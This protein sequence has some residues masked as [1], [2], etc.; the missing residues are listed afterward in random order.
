MKEK[1]TPLMKQYYSI[2]AKYPG[3]ILLFRMGDFFETFDEDAGITAKV[4]GIALTKRNNGAAGESPLAG[5]PHH[6]LDTY[7]PKLIKAGYRV[8]VCEQLEDPKFAKGIVKRGVIEVVTPG[9]AIYDKL[10]DS[11]QNNYLA[12]LLLIKDKYTFNS[13]I[14]SFCDISTGEFSVCNINVDQIIEVLESFQPSELL[15][16]KTQKDEVNLLINQLSYKPSLTKLED[17]IFEPNFGKDKLINHFG[18]LNLKA[19]GIEENKEM[20]SACGAII[21][22]LAE[23]QHNQLQHLQ[24][25]SVFHPGD[26]MIL[27]GPTKRNLEITN[28]ISGESRGATLFSVIDKT[29]TAGGGRLLRKWIN[30]PLKNLE[31]IKMRLNIVEQF[32]N[33]K[34]LLENISNLLSKIGDLERLI[35]KIAFHRCNP[36]DII[37]LKNSLKIIPEIK[38]LLLDFSEFSYITENLSSFDELVHS[39]EHAILEDPTSNLGTGNVFKKGF[40]TELDSYVEAKFSAKKWLDSYQEKL[41]NETGIPTLKIGFN[42][43]FGYYIEITKIHNRKVPQYLERKQTLTNAERYTSPELKE[44]EN[45]IYTAEEKIAELEQELFAKIKE[46]IIQFTQDIQKNAYYL[47]QL[48]CLHSFALTALENNYTK[49]EIGDFDDIIITDGRH[50]VVEKLLPQGVSYT[51]NSTYLSNQKEQIHIITGPNM[52]GKSCYLRQVAL[53]TLLAHIGSYVP[54]KNAKISIVDRI[55]T[56]VGA[57]DNIAGGESTFLIEMQEAG[58]ILNNA[59]RKSLILLDELGRGT[60]T[61]DGL[62]IA[63][64]VTEYIHNNIGAKTLFATHFHELNHLADLYPRIVNYHIEVIDAGSTILFTH[65]VLKGGTDHSFGIYVAKIAGIPQSVIDRAKSIMKSFEDEQK[66]EEAKSKNLDKKV[67][68]IKPEDKSAQLAIFEFRDDKLRERILNLKLD[69]ITPIQ[70]MQ[71][72]AELQNEAKFNK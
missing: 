25:I 28:T 10:L 60:A 67:K 1:L 70:A 47:A 22:Y 41:R 26:F 58:N 65:N 38:N 19:F 45:K 52:S 61:S 44:F 21:Y 53:I 32:T 6:Q 46:N 64:A 8:A 71:I 42:N 11:K 40:S 3:M 23:T 16:N 62:A 59:T 51:P 20:I 5:F 2:K 4:C 68:K 56:R 29:Q 55:F 49:P 66:N 14:L 37:Y 33:N 15:I 36:R 43:V 50:P 39:I 54:A 57:H 17:W 9:V 30:M 18:V 27:D 72:L 48:D 63:W 12:S 69:M 34:L 24:K 7:L 35:S 31:L 13:A